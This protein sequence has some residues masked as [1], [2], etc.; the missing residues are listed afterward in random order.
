[1]ANGYLKASEVADRLKLDITTVYGMCKSGELPSI[2]VG[3]KA[4]RIPEAAFNAY[5]ARQERKSPAHALLEETQ[6]AA[7]EEMIPVLEEQA[8]RFTDNTGFTPHGFVERWKKGE[9]ED[10][11]ANSSLV[12]EALS[13]REALDRAG[14]G[15]R[16]LA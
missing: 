5:L 1:M 16:I 15:D 10:T 12:M 13:L 7:Y 11:A 3:V 9:V 4:V 14:I 2:K 6:P 8:K